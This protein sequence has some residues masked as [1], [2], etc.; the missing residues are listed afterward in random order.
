MPIKAELQVQNLGQVSRALRAVGKD[1]QGELKAL[2]AEAANIVEADAKRRAPV[3]TGR[4][5]N[6]IRSSGQARGAVVRGGK[7]SV[8]YYGWIDFGGKRGKS[9]ARRP[10]LKRG[11]ILYP[12]IDARQD[13][14]VEVYADGLRKIIKKHDL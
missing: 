11:R 14:V 6:S 8:P 10:F 7:A 2:G 12:A 1:A 4:L 5:R 3:R 9:S 13:E